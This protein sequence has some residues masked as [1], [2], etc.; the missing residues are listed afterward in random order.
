MAKAIY[1]K[2]ELD[3][4]RNSLGVINNEEA[5]RMAK[6]LGGEVGVEKESSQKNVSNTNTSAAK[7]TP[8][9]RIETAAE[10]KASAAKSPAF[11][12]SLPIVQSYSERVKMDK[13]AY[14]E[15]FDIKTFFQ[16]TASILSLAK[17]PKDYISPV[18]INRRMNEYY[19]KISCLVNLTRLLLPKNNVQR[20]EHL[21]KNSYPAYCVLD[22]IRKWN[23]ER[24]SSD[25]SRMQVHPRKVTLNDCKE[26]L[27]AIYKPIIILGRL[28]PEVQIKASYALLY[29][30][31]YAENSS[32]AATYQEYIKTALAAFTGIRRDIR[33][34]IYPL[35]MKLLSDQYLPCEQFFSQKQDKILAFLGLTEA[36]ILDPSNMPIKMKQNGG[37]EITQSEK[38]LEEAAAEAIEAKKAQQ[39]ALE[40]EKELMEKGLQTLENIFPKAGWDQLDYYYDLYPYFAKILEM[41]KGYELIAPTDPMLLFCVLARILEELF[42]GLRFVK[43][44]Q[45]LNPDGSIDD[46]GEQIVDIVNKW[47]DYLNEVLIKEYLERLIE[48]SELLAGSPG[49]ST[50]NFAIRLVD[51]MNLAKRLF[52]FP[53]YNYT[54]TSSLALSSLQKKGITPIFREIRQLRK[55]LSYFVKEIKKALTEGGAEAKVLCNGIE[56]PWSPYTFQIINPVSKRLSVILGQKNRNNASLVLITAEIVTILDYYENN[57]YSWAYQSPSKA[58]FRSKDG[59][60]IIPQFGVDTLLD[61]DEIFK[62]TIKELR[63]KAAAQAAAT[64]QAAAAQT[65]TAQTTAKE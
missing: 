57:E 33:A 56:N 48:Y 12:L 54:V 14:Q 60:G 32:K 26:I 11:N 3:R 31:L 41:K 13:L 65:A 59:A 17:A 34:L 51:E 47:R 21:K 5:K 2:G 16:L 36:N 18:F 37:V 42:F 64:A 6:V 35:L 52:F 23:I 19:K 25:L 45:I 43:F 4:V 49:A 44:S 55:N 40:A 39:A 38:E 7:T 22:V 62:Q 30:Y 15:E 27:K 61:A 1:E 53:H 50:S 9:R 10:E 29:K 28:L 63:E 24:I 46:A 20:I 8:K 58:L